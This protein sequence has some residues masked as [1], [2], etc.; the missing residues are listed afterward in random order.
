MSSYCKKNN[1]NT[2]NSNKYAGSGGAMLKKK[3]A[4]KFNKVS[5]NKQ[6]SINGNV[7]H[8]YIGNPNSIISHDPFSSVIENNCC[9]AR[10]INVSVKSSKGYLNSLCSVN[11]SAACYKKNN[12]ELLDIS[13]SLNKHLRSENRVQSFYIT[14]LK[15]QCSLLTNYATEI[16]NNL[17]KVICNNSVNKINRNLSSSSRIER[18]IN[19]NNIVKTSNFFNGFTPDYSLYYTDSSLYKKIA[20]C[21]LHNPPDAKVLAC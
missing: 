8:N 15:S 12:I 2:N 11:N 20:A 9:N 16:S 14:N 13:G 19:C 21:N 4:N 5:S 10:K 3:Y 6:F 1:C 17:T 18:L 7:N